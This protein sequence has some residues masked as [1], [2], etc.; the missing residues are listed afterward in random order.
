MLTN[1]NKCQSDEVSEDVGTQ[2]L[3]VLP[4]ALSEEAYVRVNVVPAE[5]LRKQWTT[6]KF[7]KCISS[8]CAVIL[9]STGDGEASY[10]EDFGCRDQEG[11]G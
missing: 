6:D 1:Q 2:R 7:V 11:E 8:V 9:S 3:I 4:V 10:L 5:T